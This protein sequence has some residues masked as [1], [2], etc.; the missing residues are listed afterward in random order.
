MAAGAVTGNARVIERRRD[1]G[2][3]RVAVVTVV[4]TRNVR[5]C[6]TSGDRAIVARPAGTDHIGVI[7]RIRRCPDRIVMAILTDVGCVDVS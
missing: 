3:R 4:A 7:D 2:R 1:P 6:L 5:R